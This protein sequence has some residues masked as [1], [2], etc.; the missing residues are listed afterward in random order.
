MKNKLKYGL[1][2]SLFLFTT[3]KINTIGLSDGTVGFSMK[4][5]SGS[6]LYYDLVNYPNGIDGKGSTTPIMAAASSVL[7]R[8]GC[9][10]DT[11]NP[12][13]CPACVI[14][15]APNGNTGDVEITCK[16]CGDAL[17]QKKSLI[18]RSNQYINQI[19]LINRQLI[20][21]PLPNEIRL[22]LLELGCCHDTACSTCSIE[23]FYKPN[24]AVPKGFTVKCNE[25]GLIPQKSSITVK[26]GDAINELCLRNS[27]LTINKQ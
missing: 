15:K 20:V 22:R 16:D 21:I 7:D 8:L 24:T 12:N 2:L 6:M 11:T 13:L 14:S 19:T 23:P 17:P 5:V 10:K 25:C 9:C 27:Q 1:L 3:I 26:E 18:L 4:F